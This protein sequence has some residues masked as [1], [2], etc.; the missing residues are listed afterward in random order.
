MRSAEEDN[1]GG[2]R[3]EDSCDSSR[4]RFPNASD[5]RPIRNKEQ[6][7]ADFN[8]KRNVEF[9]EKEDPHAAP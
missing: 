4:D 5:G 3:R 9:L 6:L 1:K 7:D 2:T 8:A